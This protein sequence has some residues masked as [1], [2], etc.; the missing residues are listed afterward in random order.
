MVRTVKNKYKHKISK[1]NA[2][3]KSVRSKVIKRKI[4]YDS[5]QSIRANINNNIQGN[6][7]NNNST[8][9]RA[10]MLNNMG[11]QLPVITQSPPNVNWDM[12]NR[13]RTQNDIKQQGINDER[14]EKM[15][16]LERKK[17]LAKEE[18]KMKQET[19]AEKE[20]YEEEKTRRENAEK[21]LEKQKKLKK[22][23]KEENKKYGEILVKLK[24]TVNKQEIDNLKDQNA[25]IQAQLA[26]AKM[27]TIDK[28]HEIESNEQYRI[29]SSLQ[30]E[31]DKVNAEN[32]ALQKVL[33]SED[34]KKAN[35]GMAKVQHELEKSRYENEL[36]KAQTEAK[37]KYE[38]ERIKREAALTPEE[39]ETLDK[40]HIDKI[41]E[42]YQL[43]LTEEEKQRPGL[44]AK[45]RYDRIK[46]LEISQERKT[47]NEEVKAQKMAAY[48]TAVGPNPE[49]SKT[50]KESI[51][52]AAKKR[53][54]MEDRR[55]EIKRRKRNEKLDEEKA[56]LDAE[57]DY[58]I[59]NERKQQLQYNTNLKVETLKKERDVEDLKLNNAQT[60]EF[61]KNQ[62][63]FN[64]QQQ[65]YEE[66][67]SPMRQ[68][69]IT[70]ELHNKAMSQVVEEN[71]QR[72]D[73]IK[74]LN[75]LIE[76]TGEKIYNEFI[77]LNPKYANVNMYDN[78]NISL[79][80]VRDLYNDFSNF[81]NRAN[82]QAPVPLEF[83]G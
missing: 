45:A 47:V 62:I 73:I 38:R 14:K 51:A 81:I 1:N 35:E 74:K 2:K 58:L 3:R 30:R 72:Y 10:Q 67:P 7:V 77:A 27:I 12:I 59:S 83:T 70:T 25:T 63:E 28:Q 53:L 21:E 43:Q 56:T 76:A 55:E 23:Y 82:R 54:Q 20:K 17:E 42:I 9:A 64:I 41:K 22:K 48:Q 39:Y 16:Q 44:R 65:M 69:A 32:D 26:E 40:A 61:Q 18:Q 66:N 19:K 75:E 34:F 79:S 49:I 80:L 24:K 52:K 31:L 6:N 15:A 8:S 11:M 71:N 4:K 60:R 29:K 33:D 13:L 5:N 36:L 68:M 37:K 50:H 57:H 46:E 78:N